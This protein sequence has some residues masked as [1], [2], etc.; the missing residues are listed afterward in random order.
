[1]KDRLT[2]D[3]L[4]EEQSQR[5]V[6]AFD[7]IEKKRK[8]FN[9]KYPGLDDDEIETEATDA[10]LRAAVTYDPANTAKFKTYAGVCI[11][12]A[13]LNLAR[14]M[15]VKQKRGEVKLVTNTQWRTG[16]EGED[17]SEG[18]IAVDYEDPVSELIFNE[19]MAILEDN[20]TGEELEI[21]RML[22][23][24]YKQGSIAKRLGITQG[25]A[26]KKCARLKEKCARLLE[27]E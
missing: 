16:D 9:R 27:Y 15:Q 8:V 5:A 19:S 10:L 20:C 17:E 11:E 6:S 13:L 18:V 26:S 7:L 24:G 22:T 23:H 2:F 21:L 12:N 25:A 14:A 3:N 4:T 1:M